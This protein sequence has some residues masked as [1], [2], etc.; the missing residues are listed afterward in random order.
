MAEKEQTK[1]E[2]TQVTTQTDV[3]YKLENGNIVSLP[4]ML[5]ELY[6]NVLQIKKAVA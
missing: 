1:A 2:I 4:E 6:N 3:A 5:V